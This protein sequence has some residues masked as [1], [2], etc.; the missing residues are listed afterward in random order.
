MYDTYLSTLR[1]ELKER[2]ISWRAV[3]PSEQIASPEAMARIICEGPR[4]DADASLA[5]TFGRRL[6]LASHGILGY[7]DE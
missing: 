7:V 2:G 4:I 5:V 3:V 1:E 6:N